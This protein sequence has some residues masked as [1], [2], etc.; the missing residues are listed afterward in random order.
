MSGSDSELM[1]KLQAEYGALP[2]NITPPEPV[3]R[4][5]TDLLCLMYSQNTF[6]RI[7]IISNHNRIH[8]LTFRWADVSFGRFHDPRLISS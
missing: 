2:P 3:A 5:Q 1:S 4:K 8:M 7:I 6:I